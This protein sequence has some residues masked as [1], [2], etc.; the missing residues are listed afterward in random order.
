MTT[1]AT[2]RA[3]PVAVTRLRRRLGRRRGLAWG[4][5]LPAL[6]LLLLVGLVPTLYV[7]ALAFTRYTPGD[8]LLQLEFVGLRNFA[9]AFGDGR[10][11]RALGISAWFVFFSVGVQLVLGMLVALAFQRV[12]PLVERLGMTVVLVPMMIVPAVVGLIWRLILNETY[13]PANFL[14]GQLG[15]PQ[16]A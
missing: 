4:L 14:L 2:T 12:N 10:F 9:Q 15:L 7:V 16:P 1:P 3:L 5:V 11:W 8:P 6:T 13:G